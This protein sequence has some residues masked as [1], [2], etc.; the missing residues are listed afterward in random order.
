MSFPTRLLIYSSEYLHCF[1]VLH[2]ANSRLIVS[3][4]RYFSVSINEYVFIVLHRAHSGLLMSIERYFDSVI[5]NDDTSIYFTL[6]NYRLKVFAQT[7]VF[8][9]YS[10]FVH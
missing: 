4:Q 7:T 3:I 8:G 10:L 5:K 9:V 6:I 2:R 1:I